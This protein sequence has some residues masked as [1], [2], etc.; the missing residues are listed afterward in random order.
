M[1]SP[2][3]VL[4]DGE[5]VVSTSVILSFDL[6][7]AAQRAIAAAGDEVLTVSALDARDRPL[8]GFAEGN[9]YSITARIYRPDDDLLEYDITLTSTTFNGQHINWVGGRV[10]FAGRTDVTDLP[11]VEGSANQTTYGGRPLPTP[12]WSPA[13]QVS[14]AD[15]TVIDPA[16]VSDV[17]F[18]TKPLRTITTDMDTTTQITHDR[19]YSAAFHPHPAERC[20]PMRITYLSRPGNVA[21][22]RITWLALQQPA[23]PDRVTDTGAS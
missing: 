3:A 11:E 5:L 16:S 18:L 14:G 4:R 1:T 7:T 2:G 8:S 9:G 10:E 15:G 22:Q 13:Q 23:N 6:T 17:D 21:T 12:P 19:V 20:I